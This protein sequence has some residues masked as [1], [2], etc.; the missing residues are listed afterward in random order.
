LST[1]SRS[2]FDFHILGPL[3]AMRGKR[4]LA[5]GSPK[6]R[7]LLGFLLLHANELVPR[8]RLIDELWGEAAP[9]TVNAVLNGYLSKLRRMLAD[10]DEVLATQAPGYVLRVPAERLDARRFEA[11]LQQGRE[12]LGRGDVQ[13]AAATLR[14]ALSLWRGPALADLAY[15]QFA[16]SEIRRLDELRLAALEERIDADLTLG[17]HDAVVAELEALAAE[18]PYRERIQE[19]L[20]LA[21]YRSGRQA[22]ALDAYSRARRTLV[23]ELGIDPG[24]RLQELERAI[25]HHDPALRA[26]PAPSPGVPVDAKKPRAWRPLAWTAGLVLVLALAALLIGVLRDTRKLSAKPVPLKGDSV[27]VIDPAKAS[28]VAEIPVGA[29][30]SGIAVGE[31]SVWVGNRDDNTLLRI[32]PRSRKIVRTIGLALEPGEVGVAAG[33]VWVASSLGNAVLRVDPA[34]NDVV[35]TIRLPEVT[36]TCCAPDLAAG[37]GVVWVSSHGGLSRI[38]AATNTVVTS[39]TSGVEAIAYGQRSLWTLA[40]SNRIERIDPNT[41]RVVERIS[42]GRLGQFVP[43]YGGGIAFGAGTIWTGPLGTRTLWKIEPVTGNFVGSVPLGHTPAGAAFGKGALWVVA[44]DGTLLLVD[45]KSER[46]VKTIRLGVY[47]AQVW[48]PIA[49]GEGAVWIAVTR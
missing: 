48:A 20:M 3:E 32:D 1:S 25:L 31:G 8:D 6:Q 24:P 13:P 27:A 15:E 5:L 35:A 42:R 14:A 7:A 29:R 10:G 38:D 44:D 23:E 26:P 2:G 41:N 30:P 11:L 45:P 34:V 19:Q 12:E 17:R 9:P 4:R 40:G 46:V 47:A 43:V 36:D 21:L 49:V 37:D 33:S 18:H 16:Q 28:V 22:E 39:R